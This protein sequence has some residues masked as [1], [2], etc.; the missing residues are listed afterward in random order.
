MPQHFEDVAFHGTDYDT[1]ADVSTGKGPEITEVCQ[2]LV[3]GLMDY[4]NLSYTC[5]M[6]L[7]NSQNTDP[8][9]VSTQAGLPIQ[10]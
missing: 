10:K 6:T 9:T 2:E 8:S 3:S 4:G 5:D 1:P 7:I